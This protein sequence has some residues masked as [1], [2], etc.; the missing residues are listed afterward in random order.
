M[1]RGVKRWGK[2]EWKREGE[3]IGEKEREEMRGGM[4]R[5][6]GRGSKTEIHEVERVGEEKWVDECKEGMKVEEKR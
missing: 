3:G 2:E 5:E 6:E 4:K 1:G